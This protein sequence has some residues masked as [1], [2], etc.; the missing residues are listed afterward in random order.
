MAVVVVSS[1]AP[2]KVKLIIRKGSTFR[3]ILTLK[4]KATQTAIDLTSVADIRMQARPSV[5][6]PDLQMDLD[7]TGG[8][9]IVFGD[10]TNGQIK[11][12]E[13]DE[14]TELIIGKRG[15]YDIE[16]EYT[17]GTVRSYIGG[18]V[19]YVDQVTR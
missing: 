15:V 7:T 2:A 6:S 12:E 14:N 19:E 1:N 13:T 10:P 18:E 5:R 3:K 8:S 4:D 17:D 9:A 16:V 11:L